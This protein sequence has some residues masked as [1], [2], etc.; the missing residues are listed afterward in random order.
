MEVAVIKVLDGV[1]PC[2]LTRVVLHQ[3]G[4][5]LLCLLAV[6]TKHDDTRAVGQVQGVGEII[7]QLTGI[8]VSVQKEF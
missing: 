1:S 2:M 6:H 4:V 8:D 7:T 3:F 5:F